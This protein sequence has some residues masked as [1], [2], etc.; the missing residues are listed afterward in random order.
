MKKSIPEE[1][2]TVPIEKMTYGGDGLAHCQGRVVFVP[3]AIPG[4]I[5]RIEIQE[6]KGDY[7]RAQLLEVL[8]AAEARRVPPCPLYRI[9]GGCQL[10]HMH[11]AAQGPAKIG[12]LEEM[13]V[14]QFKGQ[15]LP[16]IR[17][18]SAD[19]WGYRRNVRF[20]LTWEPEGKVG[21]YQPRSRHLVEIDRCPLLGSRLGESYRRVVEF[22]RQA[23]GKTWREVASI[24]AI[25]NEK[26]GP[27]LY[28]L[29]QR[30]AHRYEE[31]RVTAYLIDD[32]G[33]IRTLSARE[34]P[35]LWERV[36]DWN[37]AM[38]PLAFFQSNHLLSPQLLQIVEGYCRREN[39]G[40]TAVDLYS[41]SGFFTLPLA[42]HFRRVLAIEQ[43]SFTAGLAAR[44]AAMNHV[45]NVEWSRR[46]VDRWLAERQW[47]EGDVDLLLVDPPREG[48]SRKVSEWVSLVRPAR[49][50]YVSCS[51]PTLVRDLKRWLES[52]RYR[53]VHMDCLDMFPQTYHLETVAVLEAER[54]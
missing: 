16:P 29:L 39:R 45:D 30:P 44:N 23:D 41:G 36:A 51:P 49:V 47:K 32:G 34:E 10:Q 17:S 27:V 54:G 8:Q 12:T 11:Y 7:L 50:V 37:Y 24:R 52:G 42:G 14:R 46:P 19:E 18:F 4:E 2:V 13:L 26:E 48:L 20:Q 31:P 3:F 28:A 6:D 53:I 33:P 22:L 25:S 43:E 1:I 40:G 9:C 38:H 35:V 5:V 15:T 21:F